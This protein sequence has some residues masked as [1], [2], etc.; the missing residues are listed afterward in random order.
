M[1]HTIARTSSGKIYTWG[2]GWAGQLGYGLFI[3]IPKPSK[4]IFKK[5]FGLSYNCINVAAGHRCSFALLEDRSIYYWGTNG[6]LSSVG[7]PQK[8]E[9]KGIDEIHFD[10]KNLKPFKIECSWS[11]SLS[12]ATVVVADCR[13]FD[14]KKHNNSKLETMVKKIY[15]QWEDNYAESKIFLHFQIYLKLKKNRNIKAILIKI[16]FLIIFLFVLSNGF[17]IYL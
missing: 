15:K 8:Y 3:N 17:N 12:V 11:K 6:K 9:P 14:K 16:L 10:K 13:R 4:L 2:A 5:S 7:D 1:K